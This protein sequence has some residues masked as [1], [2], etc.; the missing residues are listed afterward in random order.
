M[1]VLNSQPLINNRVNSAGKF[2]YIKYHFLAKHGQKQLTA[3][4]SKKVCGV[5]PDYS[6]R[7]LWDAIEKGEE[8][9][10][11]AYVQVMQP[12]EADPIKLKFDPFD[13]TKVWPREQFPV[14]VGFRPNGERY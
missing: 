5:D 2:V 14:C 10:W 9:E 7:D 4:E 3:A 13:V 12:D 11:T 8:V 1:L 6:K